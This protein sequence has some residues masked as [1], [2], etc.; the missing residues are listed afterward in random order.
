MRVTGNKLLAA[1][2]LLITTAAHGNEPILKLVQT[3][4]LLGVE[5]RIDHF[6]ADPQGKR[7]YLA[8]LGN[9]SLEVIDL[10]AGKRIK[11]NSGLKKPTGVRVLPLGNVAAASGNDGKVRVFDANLKLLGTVDDLDDAD[12]VRLDPGG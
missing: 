12:N 7:L 2:L 6:G 11:S 3:I 1:L 5:G 4:P 8:A 10:Q 9:D